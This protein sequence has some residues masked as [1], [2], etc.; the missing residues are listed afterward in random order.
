MDSRDVGLTALFAGLYAVMVIVLAP[1]SFGPVQL[2]VADVLLPLAALFGWPVITGATV[3][4]LVGNA[5]YGLGPHDL[6]L[7][8]A[9]NLIATTVIFYLRK[10]RLLA[11]FV[12]ALPIGLIVGGGYLW[13]YFP[14]PHI[15]GLTLPTWVAMMI[16]ITLSSIIAITI[17][18]YGILVTLSRPSIIEPLKS[19]GVK[20]LE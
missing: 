10:K 18:G 3:G 16:S 17:I 11:C 6:F 2:R 5:Y 20:V 8:P 4:C 1:I 13:L 15:F 9:A 19:R 14:P 12:G 7:R